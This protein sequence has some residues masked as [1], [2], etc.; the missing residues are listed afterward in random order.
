MELA[1]YSLW[2]INLKNLEKS[3]LYICRDYHIQPSEIDKMPYYVYEDYLGF[4]HEIQKAEEE[5]RKKE[6]K[7]NRMPSMNSMMR[8][9]K[10][11]MPKVN[12]PKFR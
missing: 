2:V 4:I 11:S 3:K 7:N 6:E 5:R 8:N 1:I 9:V 10:S 12:I